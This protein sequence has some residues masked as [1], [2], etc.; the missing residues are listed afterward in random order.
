MLKYLDAH[1]N[2]IQIRQSNKQQE[3]GGLVVSMHA[4]FWIDL[5]ES[6]VNLVCSLRDKINVHLQQKFST[7]SVTLESTK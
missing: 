2:K 4:V 6:W 3:D 7:I 1:H 5:H